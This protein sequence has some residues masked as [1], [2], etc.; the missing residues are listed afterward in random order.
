MIEEGLRSTVSCFNNT[1][2]HQCV[3]YHRRM[4][5]SCV[6]MCVHDVRVD[7]VW[8]TSIL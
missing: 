7:L 6:C 3:S 4:A 5:M 8:H 2:I 1:I